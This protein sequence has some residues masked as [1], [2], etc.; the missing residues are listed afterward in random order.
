MTRRRLLFASFLLCVFAFISFLRESLPH[1][2]N[3]PRVSNESHVSNGL[4]ETQAIISLASSSP[5]LDGD[6][7]PAAVESLT[8]QTST[9]KAIHIYLPSADKIFG[10][11]RYRRST[12]GVRP[13]SALIHSLVEIHFV[14]DVGPATKFIPVLKY[15]MDLYDRGDRR[16]LDQPVIIV[17]EL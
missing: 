3:E 9:P 14:E 8:L 17:G 5:Y 12:T 4:Y 7:L 10:G 1:V 16:A 2:S 6:E 11:T 15:L 13:L